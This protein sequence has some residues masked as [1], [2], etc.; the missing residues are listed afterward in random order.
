MAARGPEP[1]AAA[2]AAD[3]GDEYEDEFPMCGVCVLDGEEYDEIIN[4]NLPEISVLNEDVDPPIADYLPE[5][6]TSHF[7]KVESLVVDSEGWPITPP[8][9]ARASTSDVALA[10]PAQQAATTFSAQVPAGTV[11]QTC[12]FASVFPHV[13]TS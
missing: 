5:I 8:G 2:A 4:M 11:A 9:L 3:D 7:H 10:S 1:V 6:Q 13:T 12:D